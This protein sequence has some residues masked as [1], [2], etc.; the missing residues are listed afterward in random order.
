MTLAFLFAEFLAIMA[1]PLYAAAIVLGSAAI[2]MIAVWH[3]KNVVSGF[4]LVV[5]G[6]LLCFAFHFNPFKIGRAHV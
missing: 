6:T 4:M 1:I 5:F 2:W 3:E